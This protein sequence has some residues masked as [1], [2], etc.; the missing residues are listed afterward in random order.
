MVKLPESVGEKFRFDDRK[1]EIVVIGASLGGP[2]AIKAILSGLPSSFPLPIVV[3]QHRGIS[4]NT[5][6][7]YFLTRSC[8]LPIAEPEDKEPIVYG[9]LYLAPADYHLLIED[10]SFALSIDEPLHYNRP[11][12]DVLFDSAADAYGQRALGVLLT[13]S[14]CD[15]AAGLANIKRH[16]G[17][18]VAQDPAT[19][20][21]PEMP[22]AAIAAKAV[23]ETL[24]LPEIAELLKSLSS[25]GT[26]KS[27]S[28]KKALK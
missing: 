25:A 22:T 28:R 4:S 1:I 13:G 24:K 12:I 3:V 19:A 23:D 14:N 18:T 16:G 17:V 7:M 21:A 5:A 8:A 27:R 15:G 9:K 11:S 20:E 6:L 26:P 2:Q 10:R